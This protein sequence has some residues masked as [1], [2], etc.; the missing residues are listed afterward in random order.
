MN[1]N[2]YYD[3]GIT[4]ILTKHSRTLLEKELIGKRCKVC[5]GNVCIV[6]A[7]DGSYVACCDRPWEH[8]TGFNIDMDNYRHDAPPEIVE[9]W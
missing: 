8:V 4:T 6:T 2:Y 3:S 1:E 7:S 5:D 9:V